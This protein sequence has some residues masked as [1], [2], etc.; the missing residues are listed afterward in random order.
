MAK[1]DSLA[2]LLKKQPLGTMQLGF[3]DVAAV[4]RAACP[5][6]PTDTP[7]G[8]PTSG[9]AGRVVTFA[10]VGQADP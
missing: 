8:R 7:L 9:S 2:R 1:Y 5:S 3:E 10:P 4:V 6:A